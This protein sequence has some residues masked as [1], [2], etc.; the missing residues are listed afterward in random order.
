MPILALTPSEDVRRRMALYWGVLARECRP[1]TSIDDMLV[2]VDHVARSHY[3]L[4]EGA[5]VIIVGS[6]PVE[7]QGMTN[8]LKLHRIGELD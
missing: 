4:R 1:L 2:E 3:A 6:L 8:F 7:R 5:T